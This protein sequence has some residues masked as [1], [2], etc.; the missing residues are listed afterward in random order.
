[1]RDH[2]STITK[3]LTRRVA[4]PTTRV[5]K[6]PQSTWASSP[7]SVVSRWKASAGFRGRS[8]AMMRRKW[9]WL[10]A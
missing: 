6:E 5:P 7:G 8:V 10:P 2:D 4:R 1:M 9:L 3:A